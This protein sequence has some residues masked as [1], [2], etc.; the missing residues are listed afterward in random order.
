MGSLLRFRRDDSGMALFVAMAAIA[1]M[2][3]L[4][5]TAFYF[6]SQTLFEA[7]LADQHDVAF[8]AASS[9]VMVAFADLR[10]Q[11]AS[12]RKDVP[13]TYAGT[14]ATSTASYAAIATYNPSTSPVSYDCTST[15]TSADGT[16][17]VVIASFEIV[18]AAPAPLS[19]ASDVFYFGG[20]SAGSINGNGTITG[21]LFV[22]CPPPVPPGTS[23]P[24]LALGGDQKVSGGPIYIQNADFTCG[25]APS[26]AVT[27]YT[28]GLVNGVGSTA[29]P[30]PNDGFIR[31]PLEATAALSFAPVSFDAKKSTWLAK[32][33]MQSSDNNLG[34][35]LTKVNEVGTDGQYLSL[36]GPNVIASG[37][38]K[39]VS[40]STDNAGLTIN[41]STASFGLWGT[42]HDDFAYDSTSNTLYVEGLVF[43]WGNL[44]IGDTSNDKISKLNYVG[45]GMIVCSGDIMIYNDFVPLSGAPDNTHMLCLFT[46]GKASFP[47]NDETNFTGALYS[48]DQFSL[49]G[50]NLVLKGSFLSQGGVAD[51]KNNLDITVLDIGN[52]VS[53]D[54][55]RPLTTSSGSGGMAGLRMSA[56]RRL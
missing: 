8:Q 19:F 5:T 1:L 30:Q 56:W 17:E 33:V 36:R 35:T 4:T 11:L 50:N 20:S 55:P 23:F 16:K 46:A 6:A 37:P 3:L 10:S 14:I 47:A 48:I 43:V 28:N 31:R 27:V 21:P 49:A 26:P 41:R 53:K 32:A 39:V 44:T 13:Y 29:N 40:T 51:T 2:F 38:Y 15:G 45:N 34:D 12:L 9:G 7:K 25:K 42:P 22:I 54:I 18:T 24:T 52:W